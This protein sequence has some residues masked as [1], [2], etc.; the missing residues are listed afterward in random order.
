MGMLDEMEK[1]SAIWENL[2]PSGLIQFGMGP[3]IDFDPV[4]FDIRSRTKRKDYK[5]VKIDH[6]EILCN[7]RIRVVAELAPSFEQLMLQTIA[8]ANQAG[9]S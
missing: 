6:E 4:C 5:I 7:N 3:D 2:L 1:P 8:L 9:E